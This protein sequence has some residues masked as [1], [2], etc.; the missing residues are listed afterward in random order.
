MN[1]NVRAGNRH[2]QFVVLIVAVTIPCRPMNSFVPTVVMIVFGTNAQSSS[3][4][5]VPHHN[6]D[7][8]SEIGV[9]TDFLSRADSVLFVG[10]MIIFSG[11]V[12]SIHLADPINPQTYLQAPTI[13]ALKPHHHPQDIITD[14]RLR[15]Q[16]KRCD[17]VTVYHRE[18]IIL[19]VLKLIKGKLVR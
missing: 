17:I 5:G 15:D 19:C 4:V 18:T 16:M 6:Q 13:T 10:R 3:A 1:K 14:V 12:T 11:F 7:H 8:L 2:L 9:I